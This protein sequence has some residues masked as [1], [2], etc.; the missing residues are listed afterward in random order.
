MCKMWEK[1]AMHSKQIV[2]RQQ[3][4]Q[5]LP[6]YHSNKYFNWSSNL[7]YFLQEFCYQFKGEQQVSDYWMCSFI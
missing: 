3:L 2:F 4:L 5:N 6:K 7:R 1:L